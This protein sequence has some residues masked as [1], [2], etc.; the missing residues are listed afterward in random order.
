MY[1]IDTRRFIRHN[2]QLLVIIRAIREQYQPN[3]SK[4]KEFLEAD[5]VLRKDGYLYFC[6]LIPEAQDVE[7]FT[8]SEIVSVEKDEPKIGE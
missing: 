6:E 2:N 1:R 8:D 3:I 7:Y 4:W 5:V